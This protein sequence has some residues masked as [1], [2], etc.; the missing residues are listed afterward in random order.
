MTC[1]L[2]P[3]MTLSRFL[4]RLLQPLYE[5]VTKSIT[6][7]EGVDGIDA[8]ELYAKNGYLR[9]TTLFTA[10]SIDNLSTV[11]AHEHSIRSLE[12]FLNEYASNRQIQE[13]TIEAIIE[14][15]T[16]FLQNQYFIYDNKVHRQIK[17]SGS[18]S[19]LSKILANID[20][21]YR[22]QNLVNTLFEKKEIFGR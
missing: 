14:L 21:F 13:I 11:F 17:G 22:Q 5:Q 8:V 10:F 19:Y 12:R 2:G 20:M 15:V 9:H 6:F 3:T 7:L 1:C 4:Y 16:I 18:G